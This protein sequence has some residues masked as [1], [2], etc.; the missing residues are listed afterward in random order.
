MQKNGIGYRQWKMKN[1][2]IVSKEPYWSITDLYVLY[3]YFWG[4]S[5]NILQQ[6]CWSPFM[7]SSTLIIFEPW[8]DV[9]I[10]VTRA[11]TFCKKDAITF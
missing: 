7:Y 2:G 10:T 6:E 8:E 5:N 11:M 9:V 1:N 4:V 3:N